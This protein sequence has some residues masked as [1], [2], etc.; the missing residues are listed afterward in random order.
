MSVG[1]QG[2]ERLKGADD[3]DIEVVPLL[4]DIEIQQLVRIIMCIVVH[5]KLIYTALQ[6]N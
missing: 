5:V 6:R 4:P 1:G 2:T 3:P